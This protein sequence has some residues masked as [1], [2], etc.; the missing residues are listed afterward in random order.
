MTASQLFLISPQKQQMKHLCNKLLVNTSHKSGPQYS[1]ERSPGKRK[2]HTNIFFKHSYRRIFYKRCH[3]SLN[4][5]KHFDNLQSF[6]LCS[7]WAAGTLLKRVAGRQEIKGCKYLYSGTAFADREEGHKWR[8]LKSAEKATG[9]T[10]AI[11]YVAFL[12]A[13]GTMQAHYRQHTYTHLHTPLV[14]TKAFHSYTANALTP[15]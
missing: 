9:V 15:R 14:N 13:K 1:D 12:C 4:K 5:K 3:F 2:K 6:L 10:K 8:D 11:I 7:E